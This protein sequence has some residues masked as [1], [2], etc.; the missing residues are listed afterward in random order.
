MKGLGAVLL[1]KGRPVI[2]MSR[3]LMPAETGY[4]ERELLS[5]VFRL[6]RLHHYVFGSK[7]KVQTS[8]KP[9]IPVWKK[10]IMAASPW[11]Q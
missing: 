5:V 3:M 10:S 7:V 2:Y 6:E 1:Q 4:I 8:H 11:L 9:L